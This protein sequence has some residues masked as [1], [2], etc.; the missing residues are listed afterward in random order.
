MPDL[1]RRA[2]YRSLL[3]RTAM[4]IMPASW[5]R[6]IEWVRS[7]GDLRYFDQPWLPYA[8]IRPAF[9]RRLRLGNRCWSPAMIRRF[10]DAGPTRGP[11]GLQF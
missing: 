7:A 9:A 5:E 8:A 3:K 2:A 1:W 4:S 10:P 11:N 6:R